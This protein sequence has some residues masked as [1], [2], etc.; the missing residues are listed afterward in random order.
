MV[1]QALATF[2]AHSIELESEAGER[3]AE[4]ADSMAQHHNNEV[5][6]FFERMAR[7][8]QQHLGEVAELASNMTLPNYKPWEYQWP[9]AE[10]PE[11]ASYEALHYRMSL[12]QAMILALDNERAAEAFYR[13][14]ADKSVDEEMAGIARRFADE[15][16]SHAAELERMLQALP[17]GSAQSHE[18]DDD[19]HMPE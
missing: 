1:K 19:P 14:V 13:Q 16:L 3:Y 17:P 7:E 2:L 18:E 10:P 11:T 8:A 12:R 9:G 15:E 6:Q 5:A 4:L